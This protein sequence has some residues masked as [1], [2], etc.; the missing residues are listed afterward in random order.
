MEY[1]VETEVEL[2]DT[3]IPVVTGT[4]SSLM[5]GILQAEH[6]CLVCGFSKR[7]V[8]QRQLFDKSKVGRSVFDSVTEKQIREN[9][10]GR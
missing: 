10:E 6:A 8:S 5:R 2:L 7:H 3:S 4:V 9:R 1:E